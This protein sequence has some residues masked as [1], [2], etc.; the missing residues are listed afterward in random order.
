MALCGAA[1]TARA[2]EPAPTPAPSLSLE[3][4]RDTAGALRG[5]RVRA[6]TVLDDG[7]FD[8]PL[9]NGFPVQL[10][11]RLDLYRDSPLFDRLER[12]VT[13]DAVVR[14]D[15]L[16]QHY[17]LVRTGGTIERLQ[18]AAALRRALGVAFDVDILP[19][20]RGRYYYSATLEIESLSL[21]ELE[22]VERWLRGELEPAVRRGR[23][24]G[25]ALE[26]GAR[27]LLIRFSG[28]P[29]RKLE[30]RSGTFVN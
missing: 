1:L 26:R 7:V 14:L 15:P 2:Q 3:L 9:R 10:H 16:D 24:V 21:T 29:R 12:S 30:A 25:N 5:P 4:L 11:F 18:D 22:E 17:D 19:S 28:L 23:D 8:V 20:G 27:R 6:G 13:W